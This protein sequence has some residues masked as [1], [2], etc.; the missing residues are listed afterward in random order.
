[1]KRKI[2]SPQLLKSLLLAGL[3][4]GPLAFNAMAA[5]RE[6]IQWAPLDTWTD[7]TGTNTYAAWDDANNW[8]GG[9]VPVVV[10]A[11]QPFTFYNAAYTALLFV[12]YQTTPRSPQSAS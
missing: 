10:D 11:S 3:L 1:M 9:V 2:N 6:D 8:A 5:T 7:D 4:A 12:S